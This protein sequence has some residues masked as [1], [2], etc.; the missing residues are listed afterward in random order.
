[1]ISLLVYLYGSMFQ[2]KSVLDVSLRRLW[3]MCWW[4]VAE[5][6]EHL[7]WLLHSANWFLQAAGAERQ[8]QQWQE[9]GLHQPQPADWRF[10]AAN[11]RYFR[12]WHSWL[13]WWPRFAW[14]VSLARRNISV[15][16]K[17][18]HVRPVL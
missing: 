16:R 8:V 5:W 12:R 2:N 17:I 7:Q 15:N 18:D 3:Y 6:T 11:A 4:S 9:L 10:H 1:M 13:I 14:T